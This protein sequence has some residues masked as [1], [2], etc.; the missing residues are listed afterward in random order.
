MY[1]G[2]RANGDV[3]EPPPVEE[4]E[5]VFPEDRP[6]FISEWHYEQLKLW[7]KVGERDYDHKWMMNYVG[8]FEFC[9]AEQ[10][11]LKRMAT[12]KATTSDFIRDSAKMSVG[13]YYHEDA[14]KYVWRYNEFIFMNQVDL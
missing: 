5:P 6:Y 13:Y 12:L 1:S 7:Y 11:D 14:S 3:Y 9:K 2:K 10:D 4:I 8:G